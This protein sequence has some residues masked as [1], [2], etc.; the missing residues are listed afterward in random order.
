MAWGWPTPRFESGTRRLT[1]TSPAACWSNLPPLTRPFRPL[2]C[3]LHTI[4]LP[5]LLFARTQPEQDCLQVA[6]MAALH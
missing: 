1:E 2:F 3:P 5:S 4:P 6:R